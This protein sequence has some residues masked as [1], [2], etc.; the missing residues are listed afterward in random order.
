MILAIV[1]VCVTIV[2]TY[3]LLNAEDYRWYNS[4]FCQ[5]H[6]LTEFAHSTSA[7]EKSRTYIVEIAMLALTLQL[8]PWH[9]LVLFV[10]VCATFFLLVQGVLGQRIQFTCFAFQAVDE[11]PGSQLDRGLRVHLL[12]LLLLLQNE[13]SDAASRRPPHGGAAAVANCSVF[14]AGCTDFFRP[15]TTSATWRCSALG[16]DSCVVSAKKLVGRIKTVGPAT[17]NCVLS[18]CYVLRNYHSRQ[19][20]GVVYRLWEE[21]RLSQVRW[22]TWA[23]VCSSTRS[24]HTWRSTEELH[25]RWWLTQDLVSFEIPGLNGQQLPCFIYSWMLVNVYRVTRGCRKQWQDFLVWL[26]F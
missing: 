4:L 1:T 16:W 14:P 9:A 21:F 2:C 25:L 3:F 7:T 6:F 13:V 8:G 18:V 24:T 19:N 20:S 5:P 23:R 10:D 26:T 17:E 15:P 11:L 22:D 12:V